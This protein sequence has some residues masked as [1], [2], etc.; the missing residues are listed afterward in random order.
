MVDFAPSPPQAYL[1][2]YAYADWPIF[3][4]F[5]FSI[6]VAAVDTELR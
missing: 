4:S 6:L 3:L 1:P 5:L 2:N